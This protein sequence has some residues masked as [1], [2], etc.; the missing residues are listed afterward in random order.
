[1]ISPN[2]LLEHVQKYHPEQMQAKK[3]EWQELFE[4]DNPGT[5]Y[6][7]VPFQLQQNGQFNIPSLFTNMNTLM[8]SGAIRTLEKRL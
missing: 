2:N 3:P 1:M 6:L 8:I 7:M 4:K 5:F